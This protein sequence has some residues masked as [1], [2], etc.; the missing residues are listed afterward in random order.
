MNTSIRPGAPASVASLLHEPSVLLLLTGTLIGLNFPLGK[1]GAA[2]GVS[3]MLWALLISTGASLTLLPVLIARRE[4]AWP[5]LRVMRYTACS[6]LISFIAPNLLLFSAIPHAGAGYTGLMFALSP[7]CTVLLAGL[8]RLE[9]PG[10]TGLLGIA[11]GLA[12][13]AIV[14]LT[15]GAAADAPA[16]GWLLA[17]LLIPMALAAGNVYR[18]LHW[19]HGESPNTLAFWGQA[20]SS[21]VLLLLLWLTHG[22]LPIAELLPAGGAALMQILVA[23]IT[24]PVSYRLQQLG[25]PV[26]LSQIGYVA[27]AVGLVV[28]TVFLGERYAPATW[29]GA[30]VIALGIGVTIIA[31]LGA[32]RSGSARRN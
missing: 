26:L 27:A 20:F 22:T 11:L 24:F 19:P 21:G 32:R 28:A 18:T 12:G 13:A 14:S 8:C 6:A 16:L 9:T 17:P 7:V 23:G 30:G 2:A 31:Q 1:V 4:L 25:G 29:A 10:R 3:P 5:S 15:R